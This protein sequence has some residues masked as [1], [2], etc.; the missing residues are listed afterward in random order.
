MPALAAAR[1]QANA[2]KC[3]SNLRQI[4]LAIRQYANDN[5]DWINGA[6]GQDGVRKE[7][8]VNWSLIRPHW[9]N[10]LHIEKDGGKPVTN[11]S[12]NYISNVEVFR[13]P[14]MRTVNPLKRSLFDI[15]SYAQNRTMTEYS[16]GL[17]PSWVRRLPGTGWLGKPDTVTYYYRLSATRRSSEMYLVG[18]DKLSRTQMFDSRDPGFYPSVSIHKKF[19]NMA[20]HDGHVGVLTAGELADKTSNSAKKVII[21]WKNTR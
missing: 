19:S 8:G 15:Q 3:K 14:A 20:F 7:P 9:A 18:D 1:A 5:D 10:F 11:L 17:V 16:P 12:V 6:Q 13:C 2:V 21:P 4:A